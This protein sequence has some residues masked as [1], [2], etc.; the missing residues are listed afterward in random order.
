MKFMFTMPTFVNFGPGVVKELGTTLANMQVKRVF[1]V[2]DKGVKGAGLIAPAIDSMKAAGIDFEEYDG[3]LPNPPD[4]QVE[5]AAERARAFKADAIVALGGGS[6]IDSAKA[7]NI[8]LSNP[9]PISA[10]DG[11]HMVKNPVKPLI[12][13]PTTSGT[14]SEVTVVSV[15][16]SM[17][18]KRKMVIFGQNVAP[19]VALVDPELTLGLPPAI[20]AATG[21]DALT[22]ALESYISTW[23]MPPTDALALEAMRHIR[24]SLLK[25]Y[26]DGSDLEARSDMLAGS[27]LAGMCFSSTNLGFV[28]SLAHPMSAHCNV[29]HG[30]ANAIGLPYVMEFNIPAIA[31]EKMRNIAEALGISGEGKS[32]EELGLAVSGWLKQLSKD[33]NIPRLREVGVP[34]ELFAT[35]VAD[36]HKE[37]GTL[38]TPRKPTDAEAMELLEKAW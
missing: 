5:E 24:R 17:A 10:Y 32:H 26:K 13:I 21:M 20:T 28:H 2:Y 34:R 23:S 9:S 27:L 19:A 14:G 4:Y 3:V 29:P 36:A 37:A 1:F 15:V 33:L 25:A 30:V 7:I 12:A 11:F 22:H 18:E 31:P 8:L 35:I 38:T 6:S 16:T